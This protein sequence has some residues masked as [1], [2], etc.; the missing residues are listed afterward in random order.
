MAESR[1][2]STASAGDV[3]RGPPFSEESEKGVL[4]SIMLDAGKILD[5]CLERHVTEES[6]YVPAHRI[7]FST[8]CDLNKRGR[9]VDLLTV[10]DALQGNGRL[11]SVGGHVALDR[12]VDQTPTAAHAEFYIE[13]VRQRHLLRRIIERAREAESLCC[14]SEDPADAVLEKV[15]QRFFDLSENHRHEL[16]SWPDAVKSAM[17]HVEQ[18]FI[19]KRGL[20]GLASGFRDLDRVLM[21]IRAANMLVLAARPSMGKTSLA[22]N[23]A[24]N[25]ARGYDDPDHQA[26]PVA[27]FSLEMSSE[28]LVLRMVCSH[29]GISMHKITGGYISATDH[30]KLMQSADLLSKAPIFLDDTPGMDVVEMRA[31]ARRLRKKHGVEMIVV[32]YL[33]L[34]NAQEFR[35]LGREREISYISG[36]L[37]AMAKELN[38][39]VMVLSQLNRSPETRDKHGRPKLSDLRESGSIEQDADV[40]MLLRRPCRYPDDADSEDATLA[41]VD[42]AKHRNGPVNADIRLNF[43]EDITR[44]TNREHGVDAVMPPEMTGTEL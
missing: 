25:I 44:F 42:V 17:D 10:S 43:I 15:E 27:V 30:G 23:I 14:E 37:K 32:D 19:T 8:I 11:E 33:Q 12:L 20:A 24:E 1:S 5:L 31:R 6:F 18:M 26:R 16:S 9:P 2:Y 7:V 21:G 28:E 22:M 40:V 35:R 34:L 36:S 3:R 41:I 13:T 4:G 38:I 29:A 39:P